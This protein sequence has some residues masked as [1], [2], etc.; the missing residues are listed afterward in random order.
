MIILLILDEIII[1][2]KQMYMVNEIYSI[3]QV[4][5]TYFPLKTIEIDAMPP[6]Q[7]IIYFQFWNICFSKKHFIFILAYHP[8]GFTIA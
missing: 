7:L 8:V 2:M 3:S 6:A 4:D 5:A 1:Q